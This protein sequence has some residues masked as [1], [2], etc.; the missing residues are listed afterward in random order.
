MLNGI[1]NI[2]KGLRNGAGKVELALAKS[3]DIPVITLPAAA[4][5]S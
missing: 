2:K 4:P 1:C 3:E 5:G